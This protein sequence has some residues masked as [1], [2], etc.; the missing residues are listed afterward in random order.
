[1]AFAAFA[2]LWCVGGAR[3]QAFLAQ[4]A[5]QQPCVGVPIHPHDRAIFLM[6][7]VH[8]QLMPWLCST[9]SCELP[10]HARSV[11]LF[12]GFLCTHAHC[13][14]ADPLSIRDDQAEQPGL[15][16]CRKASTGR[17]PLATDC[18]SQGS[19]EKPR[20]CMW[21]VLMMCACFR[22]IYTV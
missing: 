19:T 16:A 17:T 9:Q 6:S 7:V 8:L 15:S 11:L 12:L 22:D 2:E 13:R 1:M 5:M 4:A 3:C 10:M 21:F 18:V 20:C 14:R